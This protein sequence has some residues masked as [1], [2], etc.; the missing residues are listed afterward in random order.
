MLPKQNELQLYRKEANVY[1]AHFSAVS[2]IDTTGV[3]L[4]KDLRKA[5][6]K[7]GL[8]ASNNS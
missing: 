8:E 3:T 5:I 7:K 1:Y 2:A 6:E 4:I